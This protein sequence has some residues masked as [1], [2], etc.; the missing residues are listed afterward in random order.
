MTIKFT[1]NGRPQELQCQ[2]GKNVT[3]ITTW[4]GSSF[5]T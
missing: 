5:C 3:D 2:L 4:N 1:L